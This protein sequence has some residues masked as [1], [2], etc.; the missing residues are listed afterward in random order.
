MCKIKTR[1]KGE[2]NIMGRKKESGQKERKRCRTEVVITYDNH[3]YRNNNNDN[4]S[5]VYQYS[6]K[7]NNKELI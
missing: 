7:N 1:N 4:S 5:G 3:I 6:I 2:N